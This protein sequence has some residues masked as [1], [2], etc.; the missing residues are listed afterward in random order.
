MGINNFI[1]RFLIISCF[2]TIGI[3]LSSQCDITSRFILHTVSKGETSY[4]ISKKYQVELNEFFS[5][6][7]EASKGLVKGQILKSQ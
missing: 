2:L 6:N 7:P 1:Y 3:S 5:C 4:G